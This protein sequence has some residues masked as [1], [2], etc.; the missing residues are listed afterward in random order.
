MNS[1]F[2]CFL[3]ADGGQSANEVSDHV[4]PDVLGLL[5]HGHEVQFSDIGGRLE[6]YREGRLFVEALDL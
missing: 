2:V 1:Q 4:H 6:N 3:V 5:V